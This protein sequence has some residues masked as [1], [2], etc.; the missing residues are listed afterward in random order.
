MPRKRISSLL[1]AGAGKFIIALTFAVT[2]PTRPAQPH[3]QGN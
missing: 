1:L 3:A 2:G